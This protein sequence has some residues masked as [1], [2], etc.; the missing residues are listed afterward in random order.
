MKK[1]IKVKT[2]SK[3]VKLSAQ[4]DIH[5][6]ISLMQQNRKVNLKYIFFYPLGT[7]PWVLG[8][9]NGELMKKS[10]SKLIHELE[11]GVTTIASVHITFVFILDGM[12]LVRMFKCIGLKY[13]EFADDLL[14]LA[15]AR[16]SGS[17]RIDTVFDV[18]YE[19]SIKMLKEKIAP[20]V[21]YSSK[22]LLP[23]VRSSN[24]VPFSQMET[25]K[26]TWFDF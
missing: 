8:T 5:G 24:G 12:V 14:K 13:D 7:V 18:Y 21:N 3:V 25:I 9:R 22:L 19:N 1:I 20:L 15:V 11:K 6:K 2:N 10:K 26:Q 4:S 23:H 16:K 17:K